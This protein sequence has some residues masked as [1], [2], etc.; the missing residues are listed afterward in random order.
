[1][2]L[3]LP[4]QA[5]ILTSPQVVVSAMDLSTAC[6]LQPVCKSNRVQEVMLTMYND[7]AKAFGRNSSLFDRDVPEVPVPPVNG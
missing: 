2:W 6:A 7:E 1:M 3:P 4:A 5:L